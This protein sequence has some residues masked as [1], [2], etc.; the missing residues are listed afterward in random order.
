MPVATINTE[1]YTK[2]DLKSAPPDGFVYLRPLPYSM[3]V[4][5]RD[6]AM[7]MR[8]VQERAKRN[9]PA[10]TSQVIDLEQQSDWTTEFDFTYCIGDH[11]LTDV[12]GNKLEFNDPRQL[13]LV[14]KSLD[15]KIGLEIE[16]AIDRLN[17]EEDDELLEDFLRRRDS[18]SV[19]ED[20]RS[21]TD[22]TESSEP[23]PLHPQN[24]GS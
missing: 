9:Q 20:T 10:P 2:H 5:R 23:T 22:S 7:R 4:V 14:L 16:Q 18:S 11:N 3:I 21:S 15:P 17:Q 13:R 24:A 8:M 1:E 19:T 12:N 6:K